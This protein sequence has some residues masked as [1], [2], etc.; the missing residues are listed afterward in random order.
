[1]KLWIT[2]RTVSGSVNTTR[3]ISTAVMP[4]A[5]NSTI[6][7]R[8]QVT[9]EPEPRRTIPSSR[10]PSSLVISR[11]TTRAAILAS[12]SKPE[13]AGNSCRPGQTLVMEPGERCRSH[14]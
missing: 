12:R 2:S 7:A 4:C 11:S 10:L 13:R 3:E 6:W 5:D 14:H 1:L 9:T 8:R